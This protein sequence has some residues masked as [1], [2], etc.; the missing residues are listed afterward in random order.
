MKKVLALVAALLLGS[1]YADS[2]SHNR[3]GSRFGGVF[4][5]QRQEARA[6]EDQRHMIEFNAQS[7][8]SLIYSMTR[9]SV[10]GGGADNDT[11]S[12]LS[13]N[14][15]YTLH[16]NFQ[17]GGRFNYFKGVDANNDVERMGLQ[18]GGWF[19]LNGGDLQNSSYASLHL[20]TGYDQ[21]F[22]T[23]GTRDELVLTTLAIGK[24]TSMRGWG[25]SHLTW[26][27]EIAYVNTNSTT[28]STFNY[29]QAYEFRVLQFSVIW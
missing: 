1:A 4:N 22:G 19:N 18:L 16:P 28:N 15:A 14:Y 7:I 27:P 10:R 12:A 13:F 26:S 11:N 9:T 8:P 3:A 24:R 29:Q 5:I 21:T 6:P 2:L 25:V 17:L 20:G 23:Q